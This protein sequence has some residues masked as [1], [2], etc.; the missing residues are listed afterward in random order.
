MRRKKD[1]FNEIKNIFHNYLRT[2]MAKKKSRKIVDTIFKLEFCKLLSWTSSISS[3]F[4]LF[5]IVN[6][7]LH[8]AK[9]SFLNAAKIYMLKLEAKTVVRKSLKNRSSRKREYWF[10]NRGLRHFLTFAW[11]FEEN[12][13]HNLSAF[14]LFFGGKKESLCRS[15]TQLYQIYLHHCESYEKSKL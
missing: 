1:F 2:I 12:F 4:F 8:F 13:M 3:L 10:L 11:V 14:L 15:C 9:K 5:L 6:V 7:L